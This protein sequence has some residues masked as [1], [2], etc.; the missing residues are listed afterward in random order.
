MQDESL[1]DILWCARDIMKTRIPDN[2]SYEYIDG[3][4]YISIRDA[5][6]RED[7][8]IPKDLQRA[9][10]KKQIQNRHLPKCMITEILTITAIYSDKKV[11]FNVRLF[12]N[13]NNEIECEDTF[14]FNISEESHS[15]VT[16]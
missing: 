8:V 15:F 3:V 9:L 14:N 10:F 1:Q 2:M 13:T 16:T 11:V 6:L 12:R 5:I 4:K 7:V